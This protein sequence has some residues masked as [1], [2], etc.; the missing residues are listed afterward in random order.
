FRCR[1][2]ADTLGASWVPQPDFHLGDH[3]LRAGLPGEAGQEEL[4]ALVGELAGTSLNTQRPLWNFHLIEKYQ[5]GSAI[6]VRI[7]HC[8]ADGVALARVLLSLAD[9][10]AG[11]Q[12]RGEAEHSH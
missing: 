9:P 7:H 4:E 2:V 10:E 12:A 11:H 5:G 1:P 3:V 8:Y 6:V